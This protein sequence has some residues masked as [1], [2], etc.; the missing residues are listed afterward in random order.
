M[1]LGARC[2]AERWI[3]RQS[4]SNTATRTSLPTLLLFTLMCTHACARAQSWLTSQ[5]FNISTPKTMSQ[6]GTAK[7]MCVSM[8]TVLRYAL[9]W[10]STLRR[11]NAGC[12]NSCA[13]A[14]DFVC[15]AVCNSKQCDVPAGRHCH[16]R[17]DPSPARYTPASGP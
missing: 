15:A 9:T 16:A 2:R 6:S 10:M 4:V 11:C 13:A 8:G 1:L 3:C 17:C 12:F 7:C 14:T 5:R